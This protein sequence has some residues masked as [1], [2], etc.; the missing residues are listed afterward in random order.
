MGC[1]KAI[2]EKIVDGGADY[3]LALKGIRSIL[4][5]FIKREEL[6]GN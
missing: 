4:V 2:A 6:A 3:V 5:G 1:Q